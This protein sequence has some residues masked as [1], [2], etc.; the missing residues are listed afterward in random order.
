MSKKQ[1]DPP[2]I[3]PIAMTIDGVVTYLFPGMSV[4]T[5][6]RWLS[7]GRCPRGFKIGGH[8]RQF[9]RVA[10]LRAWAEAG[11]PDRKTFEPMWREE[12]PKKRAE[13]RP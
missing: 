12:M 4:R 10:E 2:P 6:R 8:G 9:W 1:D 13:P 5:W 11:F 7:S 3:E